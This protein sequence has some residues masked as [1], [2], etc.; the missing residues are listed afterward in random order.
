MLVPFGWDWNFR[1]VKG[2]KPFIGAP[3]LEDNGR[4][5]SSRNDCSFME[6]TDVLGAMKANHPYEEIAY[7]IYPLKNDLKTAGTGAIG[8]LQMPCR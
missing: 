5:S 4:R 2:S 7:D 3:Y 6:I 1:G 8:S